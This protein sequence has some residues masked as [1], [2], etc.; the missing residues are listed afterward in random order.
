M[1]ISVMASEI[2][3]TVLLGKYQGLFSWMEVL[4]LLATGGTPVFKY[5]NEVLLKSFKP[6]H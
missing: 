3:L 2:I 1:R 4:S 6:C 5:V